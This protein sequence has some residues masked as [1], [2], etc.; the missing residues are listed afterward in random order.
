MPTI[1]TRGAISAYAFGLGSSKGINYYMGYATTGSLTQ[2]SAQKGLVVGLNDTV[3]IGNFFTQ[4]GGYGIGAF[5]LS[6]DAILVNQN[7]LNL[8]GT[9]AYFGNTTKK[10]SNG[11][12]VLGAGYNTSNYPVLSVKNSNLTDVSTKAFNQYS[13]AVNTDP[14]WSAV[15]IDTLDNIYTAALQTYSCCCG[16]YSVITY[17]KFDSSNNNSYWKYLSNITPYAGIGSQIATAVDGSGYV[18]IGFV[19]DYTTF[20]VVKIDSATG[21]TVN[22]KVAFTFNSYSDGYSRISD[23]KIDSNGNLI[24]VG[25]ASSAGTPVGFVVKYNFSSGN[26]W[27]KFLAGE[28][29]Q[30]NNYWTSCCLDSS[31]NIYVCS[32]NYNNRQNS[33][34]KYDTNGTLLWN[35]KIYWGTGW[36]SGNQFDL[37]GIGIDS[38]GALWVSGRLYYVSGQVDSFFMKVPNDGS[39]TDTYT[40]VGNQFVYGVNT[41][42]ASTPTWD[43]KTQNPT[44]S[45]ASYLTSS[46][47]YSTGT[48]ASANKTTL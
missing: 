10:L 13:P 26:I 27:Q 41:G 28:A 19:V 11:Q 15:S 40:I 18:Y 9:S 32:G 22:N 35:R 30:A 8:I 3:Y 7:Y 43:N 36:S 24:I 47:Y 46:T 33:I 31:D 29:T 42:T 2:F 12:I 23:M 48:S 14:N 38:Q 5:S 1:I 37:T 16:T 20:V 39:K 25:G 44:I 6:K 4:S 34:A 17:A 45:N 21:S